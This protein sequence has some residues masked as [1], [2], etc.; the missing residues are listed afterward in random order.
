MKNLILIAIFSLFL[1]GCGES[2]PEVS[3]TPVEK[4]ANDQQKQPETVAAHTLDKE[5]DAKV[6]A[7][8][9]DV[10]MVQK[11]D[12]KTKWTRSGTPID[13]TALNASVADAEKKLKANPK[14]EALKKSLSEAFTKRGVALT[15]ARQYA[16]AIGDYRKALKYDADNAEAKKWI[17]TI[18][19]IYQ[20]INREVPPEGEEPEPLEFNK[21]KA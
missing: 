13:V 18:T 11:S 20:S 4:T 21:E 19:S 2:Q 14:D 3:K 15:E 12:K 1:I 8:D 5:K 10:P 6:T 9:G 17:A 7:P 16:A